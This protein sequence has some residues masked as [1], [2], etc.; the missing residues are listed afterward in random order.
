MSNSQ[1]VINKFRLNGGFKINGGSKPF[2]N[3]HFL[4]LSFFKKIPESENGGLE[5][6]LSLKPPFKGKF[7]SC[8]ADFS[9]A[10]ARAGE[11]AGALEQG[12][13]LQGFAPVHLEGVA[14]ITDKLHTEFL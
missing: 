6:P 8:I 7:F 12:A 2:L 5:P 3:H 10:G 13:Q 1:K 11:C 14:R 4:T 9:E